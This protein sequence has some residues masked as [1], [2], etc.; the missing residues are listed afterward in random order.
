MPTPSD[1][2]SLIFALSRF[3]HGPTIEDFSSFS[4]HGVQAWL[5]EQTSPPKGDDA[6]MT[7]R[8]K[9]VRLRIHY[10]AA[11]GKWPAL[12]EARPL[13]MLGKP[14]DAVWPLLDNSATPRDGSE[15]RRAVDEV[16]AAT[17]LRAVY[18]RYQ[19]REAM[20]Q[21]W[22][23][24]F[25]VNALASEQIMLAMPTYDRDVIRP[26]CLGNFRDMLEAVAGSAA[27]LYYLSNHSSRAGAAN[28]NYARELFE[29]H[30]LGR[31]AYLNDRY[32]RWRDV[33]GAMAGQPAGYIDQDVYEAARAFTG[34]TVEDGAGLDGQRKLPATGRFVYVENWHDGYQKR[35]LTQEFD[36]FSAALADG[37]KVLDLVADHPATARHLARKLCRRFV[38]P[39]AS[40]SLVEQTAQVWRATAKAPDQIAQVI[41]T[42]ALSPEFAASRGA[43]L[44]RPLTVAAGFIRLT[45]L[46]FVP[47]EG[48]HNAVA[49]AG[50]R[51]FG[52]PAPTGLPDDDSYFLG[53]NTVRNR[54]NL[55][56]GVAQNQWGTGAC[57]PSR[58]VPVGGDKSAATYAKQWLDLL[59]VPADASALSAISGAVGVPPTVSIE[60][61]D[62]KRLS[63]MAALAV[64]SPDYQS[65]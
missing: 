30:T 52:F 5:E 51:L 56:L 21:F 43:K 50:Q 38:G 59:G 7:S 63:T 14:I 58:T 41:R 1:N 42:I 24:H 20:A 54:W 40:E 61:M 28:E 46:D 57:D 32:D 39:Q 34:W 3:G 13:D 53:A 49:A 35:V 9:D 6:A 33:P 27:M 65:C 11:E 16:I 10:N 19:L 48:F 29:L 18:S 64:L 45:G 4:R 12:D 55:L 2:Q 62:A 31:D 22:H 8:L 36:P 37:R 60:G 17:Y 23:D 25:H 26:N 47:T 15:R 44:K